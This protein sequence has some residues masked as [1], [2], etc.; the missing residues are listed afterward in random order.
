[1]LIGLLVAFEALVGL[2]LLRGGHGT[3]PGYTAAIAFHTLLWLFGWFEA[4]YCL[5]MLP[6][7]VLLLRA[8]H[9]ARS[10]PSPQHRPPAHDTA[11]T[12]AG[13]RTATGSR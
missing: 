9:Y 10:T 3:Q 5:L 6:T 4:V 2:L 1:V 7:L 8:E 12:R 13:S 11:P